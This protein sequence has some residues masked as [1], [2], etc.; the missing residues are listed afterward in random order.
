[1]EKLKYNV[2]YIRLIAVLKEAGI[3]FRSN[4]FS[5]IFK[6]LYE[7]VNVNGDYR[8]V[9]RNTSTVTFPSSL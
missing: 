1:M 5:S 8:E 4:V 7:L 9:L 3:K 2:L 6:Y